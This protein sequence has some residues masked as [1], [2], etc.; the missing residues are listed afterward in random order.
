M[1]F[2]DLRGFTAFS[3][4]AEPD[5]VMGLLA[6]YHRALGELIARFGA[7]LT[8]YMGDG[9]MLLL[10]APISC[11]DH[12]SLAARM[13]IEMQGAVQDLILRWRARGHAIR[14][15]DRHR[16]RRGDR[17]PIGYEGR[18][19]YTAIGPVVNLASRLCSSAVDG[20][21]IIDEATAAAWATPCR[22]RHWAGGQSRAS[23]S[24]R[25]YSHSFT[26]PP[27]NGRF[28]C[29]SSSSSRRPTSASVD[30]FRFPAFWPRLPGNEN[31]S[32]GPQGRPRDGDQIGAD[33][34]ANL[35][36]Y[37]GKIVP[38]RHKSPFSGRLRANQR[39]PPPKKI[40]RD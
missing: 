6:E 12:A 34:S 38:S 9:L 27:A 23:P 31:R 25:R 36:S 28:I 24:R 11:G 39:T 5:E 13:A 32:G 21:V 4:E 20:Q 22:S 17:R 30:V 2:C 15:R 40:C 19:D 16:H 14:I 10:N 8:C 35:H 29:A 18:I 37:R 26:K 33:P 3:S 7:T 1:I